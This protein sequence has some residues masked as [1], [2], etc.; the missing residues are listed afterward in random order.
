MLELEDLCDALGGKWF[1]DYGVAPCPVCQPYGPGHGNIGAMRMYYGERKGTPVFSCFRD[2][3]RWEDITAQ[4]R[5]MSLWPLR[6]LEPWEAEELSARR[7]GKQRE[8]EVVAAR[9]WNETSPVPGTVVETYLRRRGI[10]CAIP[11]A[12][13]YHPNLW[14]SPSQQKFPGMVVRTP[15]GIH[16]TYLTPMGYKAEVD[17]A[18]MMLGPPGPVKLAQNSD[19]VLIVAE[20]I[21]TALS[22][23]SGHLLSHFGPATVWA[24]L[25]TSTMVGMAPPQAEPGDTLVIAADGD[26]AGLAA[27]DSLAQIATERKWRVFHSPAPMGQDWNDVLRMMS[28]EKQFSL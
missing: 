5:K 11:E 27:A 2:G 12:I 20:G 22:T 19:R 21:E 28:Y 17:P 18:K 24:A 3:C 6:K 23:L 8:R 9:I 14:H 25:S 10:D 1:N 26:P 4:L 16:R 13:R 15:K 7:E